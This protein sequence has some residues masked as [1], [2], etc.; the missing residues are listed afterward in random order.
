MKLAS[1]VYEL[2]NSLPRSEVFGL[3]S[4]TERA[5][6]SIPSNI[7]EGAKR[8]HKTEYIQ[9]LSIANGSV[10]ELETQLLLIRTLYK[11]VVNVE[12]ILILTDE[13]YICSILC[14]ILCSFVLKNNYCNLKP[15]N[16][17]LYLAKWAKVGATTERENTKTRKR[18]N[19]RAW[20]RNLNL[21]PLCY[22]NKSL[23]SS[24]PQLV[25]QSYG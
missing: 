25:L 10:V 2:T 17:N 7:A 21:I 9:F 16:C 19:I 12:E 18:I 22:P 23:F 4:Q 14:S 20:S 6:V 11:N 15:V 13:C 24:Q 5:A 8:N 1:Q 3:S